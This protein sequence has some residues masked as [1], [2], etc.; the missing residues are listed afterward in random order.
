VV[1]CGTVSVT[2]NVG[3]RCVIV[4]VG[5]QLCVLV[6]SSVFVKVAVPGYVI[7]F[8]TLSVP[9]SEVVA[10]TVSEK[11]SLSEIVAVSVLCAVSVS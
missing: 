10:V 5:D 9:V 8:V 7:L 4:S 1:V 2:E 3:E 6:C 11:L